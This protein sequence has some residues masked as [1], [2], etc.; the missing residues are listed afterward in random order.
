[1]CFTLVHTF[2]WPSTHIIFID[3]VKCSCTFSHSV[4]LIFSF[5]VIL[6]MTVM[7]WSGRR[8]QY[9]VP[10]VSILPTVMHIAAVSRT[11]A[12]NWNYRLKVWTIYHMFIQ[13]LC[14]DAYMLLDCN[15]SSSFRLVYW[16]GLD[17]IGPSSQSSKHLCIFDRL[18]NDL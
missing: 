3:Y 6:I 15:M 16:I 5:L 1:M 10:S 7:L 14:H 13:P 2:L 11:W 9:W 4:T 12:M 18:R 17:L 8:E